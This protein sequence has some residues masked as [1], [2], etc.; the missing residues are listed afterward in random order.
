MRTKVEMELHYGI[1]MQTYNDGEIIL[2][3]CGANK[4]LLKDICYTVEKS[5]VTGIVFEST[6]G[7]SSEFFKEGHEMKQTEVN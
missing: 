4:D 1:K 2:Q 6:F 7:Y 5:G 3:K